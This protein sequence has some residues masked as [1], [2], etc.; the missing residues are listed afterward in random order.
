MNVSTKFDFKHCNVTIE[1]NP[2]DTNTILFKM[3]NLI[4]LPR[5]RTHNRKFY[6]KN[7]EIETLLACMAA[8]GTRRSKAGF[9]G[10][11]D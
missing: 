11:T 8:C 7:R 3:L 1:E 10:N 5:W 2:I 9:G 6:S 4:S